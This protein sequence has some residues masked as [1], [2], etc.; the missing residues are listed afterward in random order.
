MG[1]VA[2]AVADGAPGEYVQS[3]LRGAL[4]PAQATGYLEQ[5]RS[6][7]EQIDSWMALGNADPSAVAVEATV[8]TF[9]PPPEGEVPF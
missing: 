7:V 1:E 3:G 5:V 8:R 2:F 6:L 9:Q 4:P